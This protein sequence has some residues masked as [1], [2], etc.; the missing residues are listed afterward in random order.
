MAKA[1]NVVQVAAVALY[2]AKVAVVLKKV[3]VKTARVVE[4]AAA[5]FYV[6]EVARVVR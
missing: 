5:A 3:V 1:A 4:V 2:A 6:A